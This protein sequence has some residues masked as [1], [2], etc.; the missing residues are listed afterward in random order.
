M[1]C[2]SHGEVWSLNRLPPCSYLAIATPFG[3]YME[4][5]FGRKNAEYPWRLRVFTERSELASMGTWRVH[6]RCMSCFSPAM[7]VMIFTVP[8][9]SASMEDLSARWTERGEE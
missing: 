6:W 2:G 3:L 1:G 5:T 7:M 4:H 9:L 8:S